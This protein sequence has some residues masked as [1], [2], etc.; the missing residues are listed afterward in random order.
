LTKIEK[1]LKQGFNY[2]ESKKYIESL[3]ERKI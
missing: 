3:E 1:L 2:D